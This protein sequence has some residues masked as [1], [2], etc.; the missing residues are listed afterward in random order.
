VLL[1]Q[2]ISYALQ[3]LLLEPLSGR[4]QTL[5][6]ALEFLVA[7]GVPAD[8]I[9]VL[10]ITMSPEVADMLQSFKGVQVVTA[11]IETGRDE[12]TGFLNPGMGQFDARYTEGR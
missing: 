6:R 1:Q 9:H 3:V 4:G 11:T 7:Q 2:T 8:R 10:G 5:R 12:E